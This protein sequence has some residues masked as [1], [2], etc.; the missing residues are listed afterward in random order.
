M[1]GRRL[2]IHFVRSAHY[3]E[4]WDFFGPEGTTGSDHDARPR[5]VAARV[6]QKCRLEPTKTLESGHF[7]VRIAPATTGDVAQR[8]RLGSKPV[9]GRKAHG[10]SRIWPGYR[11][12]QHRCADYRDIANA[13]LAD[14]SGADHGEAAQGQ[15]PTWLLP[16]AVRERMDTLCAEGVTRHNQASA[17]PQHRSPKPRVLSPRRRRR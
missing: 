6:T 3:G 4:V 14:Q 5:S 12:P 15:Q 2:S 1:P 17:A 11:R 13:I 16:R 7:L 9:G 10:R 8:K